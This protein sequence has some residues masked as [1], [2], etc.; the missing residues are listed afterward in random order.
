MPIRIGLASK[1]PDASFADVQ[2]VAAAL[3]TQAVRDLGPLWD[4]DATVEAVADPA[5]I[6]PDMQPIFIVPDTP[7]HVGGLHTNTET[8]RPFAVVLV[9]RD[10]A[11][12]ASHEC[13]EMLVD[14]TGNR[15]QD[16][17]ALTV[18]D[19][20]VQDGPGRVRYVVEAC[21]PLE[22]PSHAYM[23][24]GTVVCD[25][26]TPQYFDDHWTAGARYSFTGSLVRPRE[27]KP[28]GYVSWLTPGGGI[29]QLRWFGTPAIV[30]LPDHTTATTQDGLS[31]RQFIDRHTVTPAQR[32]RRR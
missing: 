10:W 28:N 26:Y 15:M 25:F 14:P 8:G 4:T 20:A 21:D 3:H 2:R 30:A 16:G 1:S 5:H 9:S 17:V 6:P 12:A 11:L 29:E 18:A 22:D 24:D 13:V 27:V 31:H 32:R 19:G 23:I 7:N